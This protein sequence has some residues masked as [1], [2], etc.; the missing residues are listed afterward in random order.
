[1]TWFEVQSSRFEVPSSI[2]GVVL[3]EED[4]HEAQAQT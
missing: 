4:I 3:P 2:L 1:M